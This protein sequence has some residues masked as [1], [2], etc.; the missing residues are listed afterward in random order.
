[1]AT[2][3]TSAGEGISRRGLA[4]RL[5]GAAGV[6]AGALVAACGGQPATP[7]APAGAVRGT[8]VVW[9]DKPYDDLRRQQLKLLESRK[10]GLQI[11]VDTATEDY[12]QKVVAALAAGSGAPDIFHEEP[13][14]V[15]E[16]AVKNQLVKLDP[17]VKRD[18]YDIDDFHP[19]TTEQYRW[20]GTLYAIPWPGVRALYVNLDLFQKAGASLPPVPWAQPS[21]TYDAL[22]DT[23]RKL[24]TGSEPAQ[25]GFDFN[26][27][28]RSWAPVVYAH[29]GELF[30]KDLRKVVLSDPPAVAGLQWLQEVRHKL[31][32]APTA[33]VYK[34]GQTSNLK[35]FKE[36]R[37]AILFIWA[38][39]ITE[40]RRDIAGVNWDAR[41]MPRGPG[42]PATGGGGQGWM[43]LTATKSV[44]AA[45]EVLQFLGSKENMEAEMRAGATPPARKSLA[46][47]PAWTDPARPPKNAKAF[48]DAFA[49]VRV[50]PLLVNWEK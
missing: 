2:S 30:S 33:E 47:S 13:P 38:A 16:L 35:L 43:L 34:Q 15:V 24:T 32:V 1:M 25:W 28:V 26:P 37:T 17:L 5:T 22:A 41:P 14:R 42:G 39:A 48:A 49:Y 21:W 45:W 31:R 36:G 46:D 12:Y 11:T 29:G 23:A 8:V 20:K 3:G 6:V 40:F 44:D 18:R 10:P 27:D 19:P 50:D 9:A 7:G 4:A